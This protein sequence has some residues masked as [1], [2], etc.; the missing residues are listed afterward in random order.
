[1]VSSI[2]FCL[3]WASTCA[4]SCTDACSI[5]L[6]ETIIRCCRSTPTTP[7]L[8]VCTVS[9]AVNT[10]SD[11]ANTSGCNKRCRIVFLI[12]SPH[13]VVVANDTITRPPLLLPG[14]NTPPPYR[15][16][17]LQIYPRSSP[18]PNRRTS[19]PSHMFFCCFWFVCV[20]VW[21]WFFFFVVLF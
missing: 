11:V 7:P 12:F 13:D 9:Q 15:Q 1:M 20:F 4:Y 14:Q 16:A 21:V 8:V 18:A 2:P 10:N 6:D 19:R 3:A 5:S 17:A